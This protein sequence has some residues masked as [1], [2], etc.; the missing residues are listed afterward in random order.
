[1]LPPL[2]SPFHVKKIAIIGAGPSGLSAAKY[3]I[4]QNA[5]DS[6]VIFEQREE[7]GGIWNRPSS[8]LET[9]LVPTTERF[10]PTSD[11][12][13]YDRRAFS[14]I[15]DQLYAN[16]PVPMMQFSDHPFPGGSLLF[17]PR[18][19]IQKYLLTYAA[20]V[21][22]LIN[23]GVRVEKL[24]PL[25]EG[26]RTTWVLEAKS[27][28]DNQ[29]MRDTFDA[30]VVATGHYAVPFIPNIKNIA[31][32]MEIH[33]SVVLHSRDYRTPTSFKDK[34]TIVVGNGA[35]GTDIALQISQVSTRQTMVSVRTA[36]PRPRL[37][38][39]A[40]EEVSEIEEFL[41]SGRGVRFKDGRVETEIDAVIFCTGFLYD[42]PFLHDMQQTL[43]T[44]GDGVHGLYQHIFCID[45]PTLVFPALNVKTP[46][47]PLSEAQ[48]AVFSAVWSNNIQ[49]PSA[50]AMREWADKLYEDEG[51]RLHV[52]RI[53]SSDGLY[54]NYLYDWVKQSHHKGKEPPFCND[55][56]F[57]QKHIFPQARLKFEK[58]GHKAISLEDLGFYYD[59]NWK[60]E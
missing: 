43:I 7:I 17:P 35:S 56:S 18:D 11:S 59:E 21:R 9:A 51:E 34:K 42:Y 39:M 49:L 28:Y 32:F 20:E 48:A 36:T 41:V 23:F 19:A 14:P 55:I 16:I 12:M 33:P 25:F 57:W 1:M 50:E 52:F 29:Q 53:P 15:Y 13:G 46:P 2:S 22:D 24:E 40:C 47:W 44:T 38:Y 26:A 31:Q 4:A 30:V 8:K 6:I 5:F 45:H 10:N 58:E 37:V 54:I 27:V 60:E 3:L